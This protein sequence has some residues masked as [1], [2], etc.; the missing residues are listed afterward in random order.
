MAASATLFA[1]MN[2]FAKLASGTAP[3]A[4][5][6]MVRALVGAGVALAVAYLRGSSLAVVDRKA[7]FWRS[8]FGTIS[9]VCTFYALSS[10]SLP[11][12][13]TVTLLNLTPV[14]LALLAPI[15]LREKTQA[16]V[17]VAIA[18]AL[19]GVVF[20]LHPTAVFGGALPAVHDAA[21]PSRPAAAVF[22]V[23]ASFFASI[24]MMLLRRVGQNESPEVIAVYFSLFAALVIGLFS[25]GDL[26]APSPRALGLMGAAGICAGFGQ[27]ALTRAYS[28]E[29]AARVSGI[30]YLAVVVSSLLGAIFLGERPGLG[31]VAGMALV[32]AGGLLVTFGRRH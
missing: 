25:L 14:F 7:L 3:W 12:G 1:L 2:F 27:I 30:G 11:L 29:H 23:L 26:R 24:A 22:A 8:V 21:G 4:T 16:L 9:M 17:A 15:F 19:V 31:A 20:V 13:D 18:V 32:V 5:V 6:A 28:L 10:R